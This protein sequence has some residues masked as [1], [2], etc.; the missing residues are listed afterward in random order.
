MGNFFKAIVKGLDWVGVHFVD[1]FTTLPKLIKTANQVTAD[2]ST[3]IPDIAVVLN[4][5]D[6]IVA[7]GIEDSGS[8]LT[9]IGVL[10]TSITTAATS[11]GLNIASDGAVVAA[12]DAFI[13]DVTSKSNF[14][15]VLT[16]YAQLVVDFDKLKTTIHT[17]IEQIEADISSK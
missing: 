15:D 3:L 16:A 13:S 2:A 8:A 6:K 10:V 5:C 17:D 7:A 4:D 14:K 1:I 11:D 12:F 9:A